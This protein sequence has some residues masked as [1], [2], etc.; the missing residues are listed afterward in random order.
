MRKPESK[1]IV[2]VLRAQ[3][4]K[5]E[6]ALAFKNPLQLLVATILSAQCTDDRVNKVT[7]NL[8]K[9]YKTVQDYAKARQSEFEKSIHSTGFYRNKA[10]NIISFLPN[11]SS[12][13]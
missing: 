9:K 4:P 5:E 12:M 1:A 7:K 10:K 8:F 2:K 3:Y 11:P 13:I 6:L